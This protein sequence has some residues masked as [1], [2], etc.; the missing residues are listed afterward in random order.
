MAAAVR[1]AVDSDAKRMPRA[2]RTRRTRPHPARRS[3]CPPCR[4]RPE[5]PSPWRSP[6]SPRRC[7]RAASATPRDLVNQGVEDAIE[8]ATGGDVSLDGELPA[9]FPA[10]VPLIEGDIT[11]AA[12]AGGDRGMGRRRHPSIADDP[13]ADAASALEGAGFTE[14]TSRSPATAAAPRVYSD[15]EYPCCSSAEGETVSYTVTPSRSERRARTDACWRGSARTCSPSLIGVIYGAVATLGHRQVLRIG[16]VVDPV[17]P[18]RRARRRAG[19]AASASASSP[20]AGRPPLPPRSASS[21]SWRCSPC[22]DRAV[23]CSSSAT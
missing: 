19:A 9:D 21:A 12:G 15:G 20:E 5:P 13:V 17:G 22:P 4:P 3:P 10:S 16:D 1:R 6:A 2:P 23:R 14:D 7:S 11:V 8:S 18:R